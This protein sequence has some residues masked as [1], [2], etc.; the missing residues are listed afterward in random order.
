MNFKFGCCFT[1]V[2]T[3]VPMVD[4]DAAAYTSDVESSNVEVGE[5]FFYTRDGWSGLVKIKALRIK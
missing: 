3:E 2:A 5:T 1:K 4:V